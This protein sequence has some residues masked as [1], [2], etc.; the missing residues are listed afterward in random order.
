MAMTGEVPRTR[1]GAEAVEAAIDELEIRDRIDEPDG[2]MSP[3]REHQLGWVRDHVGE[4][5]RRAAETDVYTPDEA[6]ERV[7][8]T[9]GREYPPEEPDE[10][11]R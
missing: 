7:A 11:E 2:S 6:M 1:R 8:S 3:A 5:T 4:D 10:E 9:V